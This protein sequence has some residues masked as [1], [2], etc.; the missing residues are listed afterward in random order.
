MAKSVYLLCGGGSFLKRGEGEKE[1]RKQNFQQILGQ[2][3]G[4]IVYVFC[5]VFFR[6]QD[7]E[8]GNCALVMLL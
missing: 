7:R 5:L 8:R 2:Y 3:R 1:P 4:N 6:P